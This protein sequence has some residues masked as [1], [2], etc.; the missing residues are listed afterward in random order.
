MNKNINGLEGNNY[1]FIQQQQKFLDTFESQ[2]KLA[3]DVKVKLEDYL[4][5]ALKQG[6][7][8]LLEGEIMMC[9]YSIIR[10]TPLP[11]PAKYQQNHVEFPNK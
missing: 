10:Y 5:K 2:L 1:M 11:K 4:K 3:D 7:K 6:I 8:S 9:D